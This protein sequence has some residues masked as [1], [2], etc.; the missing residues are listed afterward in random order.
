MLDFLREVS[1]VDAEVKDL[2]GKWNAVLTD[3][4]T[5]QGFPDPVIEVVGFSKALASIAE[6]AESSV[7]R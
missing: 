6:D 4:E 3:K 2:V 5:R 7:S 1:E